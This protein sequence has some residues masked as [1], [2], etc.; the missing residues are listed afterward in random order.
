MFPNQYTVTAARSK[1]FA[2]VNKEPSMTQQ[3]DKDDADI[4]IIVSRFAKSGQ[5]PAVQM[6]PLY[7]D[8]TS[9]PDYRTAVELTNKANEAFYQ[10]PARIRGQF[11]NNPQEFIAFALDPKNKDKMKEWGLTAPE[12]PKTISLEYI[13]NTLQQGFNTRRDDDGKNVQSGTVGHR[14][15]RNEDRKS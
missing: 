7:A 5:L 11:D 4:N 13:N 6:E 2:T 14:G 1:Q 8:F 3:S 12:Q 10:I 9:A 15:N